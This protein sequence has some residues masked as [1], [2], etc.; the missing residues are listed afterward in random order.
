MTL[1]GLKSG[2]GHVMIDMG[3]IAYHSIRIFPRLYLFLI[4]SYWQITRTSN[5][6]GNAIFFSNALP[7]T[8]VLYGI[9]QIN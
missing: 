9:P 6:R 5:D 1:K 3:Y 2:Q 8:L 7:Q 4:K